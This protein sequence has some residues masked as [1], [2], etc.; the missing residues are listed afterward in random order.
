ML[1]TWSWFHLNNYINIYFLGMKWVVQHPT[2]FNNCLSYIKVG[3]LMYPTILCKLQYVN[4]IIPRPW[5]LKWQKRRCFE[6]YKFDVGVL[7]TNC[8]TILRFEFNFNAST[9]HWPKTTPNPTITWTTYCKVHQHAHFEMQASLTL[10]NIQERWQLFLFI[11]RSLEKS[12]HIL[13]H[14]YV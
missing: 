1:C 14:T 3:N 5:V 7:K 12:P 9:H 13:Q 8:D 10:I 2:H 6:D 11:A 4:S